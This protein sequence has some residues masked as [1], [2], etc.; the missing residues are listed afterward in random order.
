MPGDYVKQL[1]LAKQLE[2]KAREAA[3]GR[4]TAEAKIEEASALL[5]KVKEMNASSAETEKLLTLAHQSYADKDYKEALSYAVKSVDA[6]SR[7][8]KER[9]LDMLREARSLLERVADLGKASA[10]TDKALQKASDSI[11]SG[12][13]DVA[14]GLSR[15]AWDIA[16]R[17]ANRVLS[18]AFGLA[19]SSLLFA[20]N[21]DLKVDKQKNA[22]RNCREA[23]ESG[24]VGKSVELI[25]SLSGAL[26][27]LTL[28]RFV[29]R[30][31]RLETLLSLG[32]GFSLE[33]QDAHERMAKG[34][35]LISHGKVEDAFG[36]LDD[37]EDIFSRAF[38]KVAG[39]RISD[40]KK[41]AD[42]LSRWKK[43]DLGDLEGDTRRFELDERYQE[44]VALL[45]SARR[46][47]RDAEKEVLL[48]YIAAL[49]PRLKLA[50]LTRKDVSAALRKMDDARKALQGD[51]LNAAFRLTEEARAIVEEKLQGYDQVEIELQNAQALRSRCADLGLTCSEGSKLMGTAKKQAM[52]GD[53]SL[54]VETL[55]SS[56]RSYRLSLENHFAT[57]IMRLEMRLA[58]AMRL[59]AD[60]AE[61]SAALESLTAKV[62]KGDFELV[63]GSLITIGEAVEERTSKAVSEELAKADIILSRYTSNPEVDKARASLAEARTKF[64]QREFQASHDIASTMLNEL[65]AQRRESLE[66]SL[67]DGRNMLDMAKQLGSESVTLRDRMQRA[68]EL[69]SSGRMDEATMLADEVVSY[70]RSIVSSE[71]DQQLTDIMQRAA[72]ARKEGVEVGE[73]EHMSEQASGALH[74]GD[75]GQAFDLTMSAR[76]SLNEVVATHQ[77][78]KERLEEG[79]T[80]MAE[81]RRGNAD[82]AE[83]SEALVHG[84]MLLR[85][86]RY[87]DAQNALDRAEEHLK[88]HAPEF[89]LSYGLKRMAEM[90][91]L[92]EKLGYTG[93][94]ER[95]NKLG[96]LDASKLESSLSSLSDLRQEWEGEITASLHTELNKCQKD[97]EKAVASGLSVGHV[98]QILS[99]GRSAL[100]ERRLPEAMRAVELIKSE[101]DQTQQNDRRLTD[102]LAHLE[103]SL[104]Q[105]REMK[106]DVKDVTVLLEQSR[107]LRRTGSVSAAADSAQR[108]LERSQNIARERVSTMM[109]FAGG[110]TTERSAWEDLR[111]ARKLAEDIEEALRNNRYRHAHLL[112]RSFREE[113]ER[114]LQDKAQAD[115]ELHKFETRLKEEA[116]AGLSPPALLK[117]LDKAKA[118]MIQGRFVQALSTV[119]AAKDELRAVSEMYESRLTD[120]NDMREALNSMEV[121]D[122]RKDHVDELLDQSWTALKEMRF[123]TASLYLRRARN[124]LDEFLTVRT[125]ELLWEFNPLHDLIKRLKIQK[126]FSVEI[127]EIE[128]TVVDGITPRDLNRLARNVELV[129]AGMSDIFQEQ[130]E[131]VRRTIE[132]SSRSGKEAGRSWEVWA[133]AET[134]AKKGDLWEA[135]N[136]LETSLNV[137][138]RKA[139]ETPE[140][141]SKQLSETLERANRRRIELPGTQKAYADALQA[142]K[143]GK[144]P[145]ELLRKA[146][147]MSRKEV[148]ST[149]PDISAELELVGEAKEGRPMDVVVHLKNEAAFEARNVRAFIFGDA[150]VKGMVEAEVLKPNEEV[151][152]RITVIPNRIGI[153]SLG[154]SVK[155]KP[156]LTD[157]DVLY[158]SKFDLDVKS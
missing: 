102:A 107:A 67:Q 108:A 76:N 93:S 111:T 114:V 140:Q 141:L 91:R 119:G 88:R 8:R 75:L 1:Q 80:M 137:L 13:L 52:Q 49:Q 20:E 33:L 83:A 40:L 116:K 14:Y 15:E 64:E 89:L 61:E 142:Q 29:Q 78:L 39:Q 124:G 44:A 122:P 131:K 32:K 69:R 126:R 35:D 85:S 72:N 117:A 134:Q 53:Y 146:I 145:L 149:Y 100:D 19:Q 42:N 66:R 144:S 26:R 125:N 109:S 37:A 21:L 71:I 155:C 79:E 151:K 154:I 104:E 84:G 135:F 30:T 12:D 101:L 98:Q 115:D 56:Q 31:A 25:K 5:L 38:G 11:D 112:S 128:R 43:V 139:G 95:L 57:G 118:L 157:E 130:R 9:L 41:R 87:K 103:E 47:V 10:D 68:E 133:D 62:R 48:R 150:E 113:L 2:Q 63:H 46:K 86:G 132:K 123:D 55:R 7:A 73:S 96:S 105:L 158:D 22:L 16:E 82:V 129:K 34:R 77:S 6:S 17:N 99:R 148:R 60:V 110:L 152:G 45:D 51:D 147:E 143:E 28:D 74:H 94:E 121:L 18:D 81:A 138:G 106:A 92:R 156:L 23:L 24:D 136:S 120:Y 59:G 90:G 27:S 54:A 97:L 65:M 4:E 58:S 3:R 36:A 50:H 70:G 153:L 127:G